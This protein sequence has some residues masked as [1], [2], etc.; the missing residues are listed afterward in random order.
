MELDN[1]HH[2]LQLSISIVSW[3]RKHR[4]D[5]RLTRKLLQI[6]EE[7]DLTQLMFASKLT[8]CTVNNTVK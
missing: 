3:A 5:I 2:Y 6:E 1:C 4:S 7:T 8:F